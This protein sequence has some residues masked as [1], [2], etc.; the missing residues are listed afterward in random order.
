MV[1][2]RDKNQRLHLRFAWQLSYICSP[3]DRAGLM[4][5]TRLH[6]VMCCR[7]VYELYR[8]YLQQRFEELVL[9]LREFYL[10][11]VSQVPV[12]APRYGQQVRLLRMLRADNAMESKEQGGKTKGT[13][14]NDGRGTAVPYN[15]WVGAASAELSTRERND[16]PD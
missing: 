6:G 2:R 1:S 14:R 5:T 10:D 7:E 11:V 4:T 3:P 16:P 13:V 9:L 15:R 8:S 12:R